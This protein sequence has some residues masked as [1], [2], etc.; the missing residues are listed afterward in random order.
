MCFYFEAVLFGCEQ[1]FN[2]VHFVLKFTFVS[3]LS[4]DVILLL[5]CKQGRIVHLL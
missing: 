4:H 3:L 1:V 5:E 2:K